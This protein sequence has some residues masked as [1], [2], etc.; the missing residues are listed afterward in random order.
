MK[1]RVA[2]ICI[3]GM[4]RS[5]TSLIARALNLAGVY[6][7]RESDISAAGPD[8]PE[9]FWEN[10]HFVKI[11]ERI[12]GEFGGGWD[13]PP[14]LPRGWQTRANLLPQRAA[15]MELIRAFD[16][17]EPW[18]WKDPRNSL[19]IAFWRGLLPSLKVI[20]C[21]RNP[22]EVAQSLT[23][24]GY[25]S[26]AFGLE[27]WS[28]Y[29]R[30]L[31]S[32][33]RA[34]RR[35]ITH[36]DSYFREPRQE[37]E[38][39]FGFLGIQPSET[40]IEA[41]LSAVALPLRHNRANMLSLLASRPAF[42]LV[43]LYQQMCAEAGPVLQSAEADDPPVPSLSKASY[44]QFLDKAERDRL[45]DDVAQRER[46][47]QEL[48]EQIMAQAR[49]LEALPA[50]HDQIMAQ[51]RD[52]ESLQAQLAA[53]L[54]TS[55]ALRGS[56]V[57]SNQSL[58]VLRSSL[59]ESSQNL[60]AL[61][62]SLTESN[63]TSEALRASLTESETQR[64]VLSQRQAEEAKQAAER[65]TYIEMLKAGLA[66]K[67]D[68][69]G[70]LHARIG[71]ADRR[72]S[73]LS[74]QLA[75]SEQRAQS[76]NDQLWEVT[77]SAV[78]TLGL[79]LRAFRLW[80]APPGGRRDKL[81]R[82]GLNGL[83]VWRTEG[84]RAFL[85]RAGRK[86][87][88]TP[89]RVM[90]RSLEPATLAPEL[91]QEPSPSPRSILPAATAYDVLIFPI[92]EW[93]F[94]FQ[95]PQ[96]IATRIARDGHRVFYFST[97]FHAGNKP[98]IREVRPGVFEVALPGPTGTHIY[99]QAL[100]VTL[101]DQLDEA[102]L[103]L[104][105]DCGITEA[106][107]KVDLPFWGPLAF[108]LRARFGWK[109]IY[110][111]MDFHPGFSNTTE[112][113]LSQ[114]EALVRESDLVL[115][116]SHPLHASLCHKNANCVLVPNAAEVEHF[117]V[118][119]VDRPSELR[120]IQSPIIG[121]YGAI[122]EWFDS[123]LVRELAL[124]H[125]K[126]TF[127]LIGHTYGADLEPLRGLGN[128]RLLEEKPYADL[129]AYLHAFDVCM[130]P[131]KKTPLTEATNPVKLFEFL[132]AGRAV[133]AT[134]LAELRHYRDYVNLASTTDLW[135][136]ALEEA[137][138]E[139][140]PERRAKRLEFARQNTWEQRYAQIR[141]GIRRLYGKASIIVVTYNGLEHTR[142][143]LESI[144]GA[145]LHPDI[146]VIV[147]DNAST[148]GTVAY[149]RQLG[150]EHEDL[151]VIYNDKNE[152][153]A[154]ANNQGIAL[155]SGKYIVLLNN[156]TVVSSGWLPRLLRYLQDPHVGL[157]GPLTNRVWNEARLETSIETPDE[158]RSLALGL[159][160]ERPNILTPVEMLAMYCTAGRKEVFDQVGPLDEQFGLGMF[161]DNDYALR[162]RKAGYRVG[163]AE[164]VFIFHFG[165]AGFN[166]L[167]EK[168]YLELF[169]ENRKKLEAKWKLEWQPHPIGTIEKNRRFAA[170]LYHV[171]VSHKESPGI[172]IFPPTI[173]WSISLIQRPHQLARALARH[174]WLVFFCVDDDVD[175]LEGFRQ[176]EPGLFLAR[177][178]W[179]VFDLIRRPIV[180]TLPY[181]RRYLSHF[182]QPRVV[183]EVIDDLT[184]FPGD[185]EQLKRNHEALLE[186]AELVVVTADRLMDEV[187][188]RRPD[189]M[190]CPNGVEFDHFAKAGN[191]EYKEPP[192]DLAS[193]VA[194]GQPLIGYYGALARWFDY[195]LVMQVARS[196]PE[197]QI[198]LI[199]QELDDTLRSS[200]MLTAGNIHWLR[201][202]EYKELPDYLRWFDVAMIPFA[203][204]DIT[205]STS[206]IKLFEYMAAA[207][208]IVTTDL[209]ECSKYSGV[210]IAHDA[211]EFV[212]QVERALRLGTDPT[213]KAQLEATARENTWDRRV[214]QIL[215]G[216]VA[217]EDTA[218]QE[219][220]STKSQAWP[221]AGQVGPKFAEAITRYHEPNKSFEMYPVWLNYSLESNRR[222]MEVLQRLNG[223][224][225][226]S[227][228]QDM[229]RMRHLD[230]GCAYGGTCIAFARGG[231]ESVGIDLNRDF[232]R[233][234]SINVADH[235]GLK[236]QLLQRDISR[237]DQVSDLGE[238]DFATCDNVIEHVLDVHQ[239]LLNI[240]RLL[241]P[242][243]ICHMA[244]PNSR[245]V[246]EI[247]SDGHF[248]KFGISLLSRE[249]AEA[250][251]YAANFPSSYDV[252]RFF[253]LSD[254]GT[255]FATA[256]L[257]FEY[258][259][260]V[261]ASR[262]DIK[263]LKERVQ[264]L[265]RLFKTEI[266]AGRIPEIAV[267]AVR[268]ALDRHLGEFQTE[269]DRWNA[270]PPQARPQL[271]AALVRDYQEGLW[272]TV[273]RRR[274]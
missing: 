265:T 169:E 179:A 29:N 165:Q 44:A 15:A 181:N 21:L 82:A 175:K 69:L 229:R 146:E 200:K 64:E 7:G 260:G 150:T 222:G 156:D 60:E 51:A 239:A 185:Q 96:Q 182:R 59:T 97:V 89:G 269:Y 212:T 93:D 26:I 56:L 62:S 45:K 199:G 130:I 267:D 272:F 178:P 241:K 176:V 198:V 70:G 206:P 255:M 4:H 57:E 186:E 194:G 225:D 252:G 90:H 201:A 65:G 98:T 205:L 128:V 227:H 22:L 8:N 87:A 190:M 196:R 12:L 236:L 124:K 74:D 162:V 34:E 1:G 149:L 46:T 95:R 78:W 110:D 100:D 248:G 153:F 220:R 245:S 142:R 9:G 216:L 250:Y 66:E 247:S 99:S 154:R 18:G 113:M 76:L 152:G 207:K 2:P 208:P 67:E 164:D 183:Y 116:S 264:N 166:Q 140:S 19:T 167:G 125:R 53:S 71:D 209:P 184:V 135:S 27:L 77:S 134:D 215:G 139:D 39:L 191:A 242:G 155:A 105:R 223:W 254:Y 158:M 75:G 151:K 230:V 86:V 111:C 266:G 157:V 217:E 6:L 114:E 49:E 224:I 112:A 219:G 262:N 246:A 38:R 263:E 258:Q 145:S 3:A 268:S 84:L 94:R 104:C 68:A 234:A 180:F 35:L 257:S 159:A 122:S 72:L 172:A 48:H 63:Q 171:L 132:S 117:R 43:E 33:V 148:D 79:R 189:A 31:L 41:A 270:S 40:Q 131:F 103:S 30:R 174:G 52:L 73:A 20:I 195:D 14:A 25:S 32:A 102:V 24:R 235:P 108:Q 218:R 55:E 88:A 91:P 42:E 160:C 214:E 119:P 121:Y 271:A 118:R 137:L 147:V 54:Q 129:P 188:E 203:V 161:E 107:C 36:Y 232:L 80:I 177:I 213:Y 11:N 261:H 233:L 141:E 192:G 126:W 211:K 50:L 83:R 244:I 127:L 237:W 228:M 144:Y 256:G 197:W 210:L 37:L 106:V 136:Q 238:F 81:F 168:R 251:Y 92:I 5:G 23:R 17:H 10:I 273:A 143:C 101:R 226:P 231:A 120:N 163:V 16:E 243:G 109:V 123:A 221:P 173:G 58:E 133:V 61:R 249:Q 204:N 240:A 28:T 170:D 47:V 274:P 193:I 187:R 115:A 13:R 138:A 202:R 259:G 85:L 253:T